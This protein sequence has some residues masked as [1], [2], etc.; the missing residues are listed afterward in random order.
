MTTLFLLQTCK[1]PIGKWLCSSVVI[2]SLNAS[3]TCSVSTTVSISSSINSKPRWQFWRSAHPPWNDKQLISMYRFLSNVST[4]FLLCYLLVEL[5]YNTMRNVLLE[6]ASLLM[7]IFL[8][9]GNGRKLLQGLKD[10]NKAVQL[11]KLYN[12]QLL[13][14]KLYMYLTGKAKQQ[15]DYE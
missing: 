6:T 9:R 3:W 2:H 12:Q 1:R 13:L 10:V 4:N 5:E 11:V 8:E 15:Q 14:H 7:L